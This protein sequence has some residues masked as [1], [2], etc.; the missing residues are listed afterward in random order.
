MFY[1]AKNELLEEV[2][3]RNTLLIV[4]DIDIN[5]EM[6]KFIFEE[7]FDVLEAGDGDSAIQILEE[8]NDQIVLMFLDVIMPGKSG[9][10]VLKKMVEKDYINYIPV[11][12]IKGETSADKEA[13]AYEYGASDIIYKP[14][15]PKVIMRRTMNLIELFS[16]RIDI[17]K[18][19]EK[20]TR[21]LR[22][23]REKLKRNNEFLIN[24]LS[25]VVE[26]RSLESGEHIHRV[27]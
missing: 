23:S 17:E 4:D 3:E 15:V 25:S 7:Q 21:Q 20:R 27:K 8:N 1:D 22:E 26:F 16:H 6:L 19:L 24:A 10:E 9:L 2:M 18:K 13:K 12:I 14:F 11:I 5:R